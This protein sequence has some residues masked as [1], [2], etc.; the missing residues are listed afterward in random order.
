[1]EVGGVRSGFEHAQ[2]MFGVGFDEQAIAN[3]I[4]GRVFYGAEPTGLGGVVLGVDHGVA[5]VFT[6]AYRGAD[7]PR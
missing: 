5:G 1:M 2:E 3:V 4:E 6:R 7:P